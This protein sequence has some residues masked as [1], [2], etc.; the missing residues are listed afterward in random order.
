MLHQRFERRKGNSNTISVA[1]LEKLVC[2][3]QG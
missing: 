3:K 2:E 1:E